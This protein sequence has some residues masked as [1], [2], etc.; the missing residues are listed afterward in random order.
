M[1]AEKAEYRYMIC[2]DMFEIYHPNEEYTIQEILKEY[3]IKPT[4]PS[5]ITYIYDYNNAVENFKKFYVENDLKCK[6]SNSLHDE[7]F[8]GFNILVLYDRDWQIKGF[9][10]RCVKNGNTEKDII[11]L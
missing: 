2:R 5:P 7:A 11:F 4:S 3:K 10:A 8:C 6:H 1:K 9:A